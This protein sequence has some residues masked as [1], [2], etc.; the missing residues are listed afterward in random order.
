[1]K[2]SWYK[3]CLHAL[4]GDSIQNE[5]AAARA[6]ALA[7]ASV[8]GSGDGAAISTPLPHIEAR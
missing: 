5:A 3:P 6:A 2:G 7:S 4:A 8:G 1:M